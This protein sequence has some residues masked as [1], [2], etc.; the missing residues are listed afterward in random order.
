MMWKGWKPVEAQRLALYGGL[1]AVTLAG[2]LMGA[3]KAANPKEALML[4]RITEYWRDG[5][6]GSAKHQILDFFDQNPNSPL[7]DHLSAMLGDLY[8]QERDWSHALATYEQVS[9]PEVRSKIFFNHLQ[10]QFELKEYDLVLEKGEN[11]LKVERGTNPEIELRVRYLVAEAAFRQALKC[12]DKEAKAQ[13][14]RAAKPHYRFLTKSKYS[15]RALFPLAEIYRLLK[16]DAR[17]ARLYQELATKFPNHRERFLFQAAVLLIG[18]NKPEAIKAFHQVYE[19]NGK[20]AKL[21]AFNELILLYQTKNYESFL[22]LSPKVV[23]QMPTDKVALIQYYEGRSYY[24]MGNFEQAILSLE[25]FVTRTSER[26]KE[27]KASLL[28]LMNCARE[29]KDLALLERTITSFKDAFPTDLETPKV[30]LM[31]A[32]LCKDGG[33][34][35]GAISDLKQLLND[36]PSFEEREKVFYDL[37]VLYTQVENWENG[38]ETF[39]AFIDQFSG[40]RRINGAWR[41]LIN[42]SIEELKN[43][44]EEKSP[45]SKESFIRILSR[46]IEKG[47]LLNESEMRKY[48]LTL[49]KFQCDLG[50]YAE[51]AKRLATYIAKHPENEELAEAHLLMAFCHQKLGGS[52]ALFISHAE[53]ALSLRPGLTEKTN[54][55]IELYNAYLSLAMSDLD[56]APKEMLLEKAADHLFAS[57]TW[58]NKEMKKENFLWLTHYYYQR[59]SDPSVARIYF[60][61]ACTLYQKLLGD[62]TSLKIGPDAMDLEGEVLKFAHL[63]EKQKQSEKQITLLE[64]LVKYQEKE[65]Q[66]PWKLKRRTVLELAR[67]Y[68]LANSFESALRTYEYLVSSEP[69]RPSTITDT[70]KLQLTRLKYRFLPKEQKKS[71]H[72]E[73]ITILHTLKDL[74]IQKKLTAE[75]IHLEASLQYAEIRGELSNP[76]ERAK[77]SLFFLQR[78]KENFTTM[79]DPSTREYNELRNQYPEKDQIFQAYMKYI[80]AKMLKVE[81]EIQ[82]EEGDPK[83]AEKCLKMS[84]AILSELLHEQ[85]AIQPYLY[86]HIK[87]DLE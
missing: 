46:A 42:C 14:L 29:L 45:A 81:A 37:G 51:A 33:N 58:Q 10:T 86:D 79:S 69:S 18:E 50:H 57:N 67:A 23:A 72:P 36:F 76:N 30:M 54:L 27:L 48:E 55:H 85:E 24:S 6:Y 8:F 19:M 83:Q 12:Q 84:R 87:R 66:L 43:V 53:K 13:Y 17:A 74:Q 64:T 32:H 59:A 26:S 78:F 35:A 63:L 3:A 52:E 41:H 9:N 34:F 7:H 40:S 68:E 25:S 73:L 28:L 80:D 49:I 71:G 4:R 31:H 5:D 15:D 1:I 60:D 16:D 22:A 75:P 65:T 39:T 82:R 47:D 56:S 44:E 20:R 77:N 70:A 11:Y 21:A 62:P 61:R 2:S 38:R